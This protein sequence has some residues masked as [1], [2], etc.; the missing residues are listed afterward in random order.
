VAAGDARNADDPGAALVAL[1]DDPVRLAAQR[2]HVLPEA[3]TPLSTAI[4]D[5]AVP[6]SSHDHSC[7]LDGVQNTVIPDAYG[8]ES[9]EP[10][11]W[12]LAF[13]FGIDR[14]PLERLE[15]RLLN[16]PRK[17]AEIVCRSAG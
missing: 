11:H 9:P 12:F 16:R 4:R 15:D 14:D 10:S 5:G 1:E 3:S 17:L 7:S 8:P 13:R 6:N 2:R